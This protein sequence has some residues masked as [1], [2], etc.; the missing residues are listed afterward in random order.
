MSQMPAKSD[1]IVFGEVL[2]DCFEDG[3]RVLGGAPFNV[4]WHL[5]AFG[6]AYGFDPLLIS[7]VGQDAGGNQIEAKMDGWGMR[8]G[9]LQRDPDHPTGEVDIY[10]TN[11][12]PD[13][14]IADPSAYDFIEEP[15]AELPQPSLLYH[16]SLA[17]RHE[18]CRQTLANLRARYP[19]PIFIDVNLRRPWWEP[20][21]VH[22]L[23]R[24]ADWLKINEDELRALSS[25]EHESGLEQLAAAMV[26]RHSLAAL[27][28]TLGERGAF[29]LEADG[30]RVDVAPGGRVEVVDAVGAGDAFASVCILGI[31]DGWPWEKTLQRAQQFAARLVSQR[32]AIIE[33]R[34]IYRGF[35]EQWSAPHQPP[36]NRSAS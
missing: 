35:L 11:G 9:G 23:L 31:L 4:A 24:H 1:P 8:M 19:A 5:K 32:G 7:R 16:G 36:L 20:E 14:T 28:V 3:S 13:F 21:I 27:I 29:V 26:K 34:E 15:E 12:Q 33:D 18:T 2:F 17:L 10:L 25:T 22:E 30:T 6:E